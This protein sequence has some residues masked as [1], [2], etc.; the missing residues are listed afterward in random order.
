M[1]IRPSPKLS[2]IATIIGSTVGALF[3]VGGLMLAIG[4]WR[5][6]VDHD[7]ADLKNRMGVAESNQKQYIPV[8]VGMV[9]DV[10]YLAERARREDERDDRRLAQERP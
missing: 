10:S 9:H 1:S 6:G 4:G 3:A 2:A 5:S 7:I 8:L